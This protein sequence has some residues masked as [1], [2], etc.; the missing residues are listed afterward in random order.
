M[1]KKKIS[2]S[3]IV[4]SSAIPGL[5]DAEME[6]MACL[7]QYGE[8]PAK[9]IQG[10]MKEFRPL[11]HCSVLTLLKRLETRELVTKEKGPV[12]K[13]FIF[14]PIHKP[15]PA[16]RLIV[17]DLIKRVFRGNSLA[18]VSSLFETQKL[19]K[20]ELKELQELLNRLKKK[21]K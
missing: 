15:D 17:K 7:W 5:P 14:K 20:E 18:L 13:A 11:A 3:D 9:K 4:G 2:K 12:G 19:K 16:Y 6:V 8:A 1:G 21:Q 10:L